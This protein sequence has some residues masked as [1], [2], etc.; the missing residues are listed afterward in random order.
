[1][2]RCYKQQATSME[3]QDVAKADDRATIDFVGSVD[4]E[5]F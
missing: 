1:M 4:G 3:S 2:D 5:E